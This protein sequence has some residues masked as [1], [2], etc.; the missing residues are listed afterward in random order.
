MTTYFYLHSD[1]PTPKPPTYEE[2]R[3]SKIVVKVTGF[4]NGKLAIYTVHQL[5]HEWIFFVKYHPKTRRSP[6]RT[7]KYFSSHRVG[8]A[9]K[10]DPLGLNKDL[11]LDQF[12][13]SR[14]KGEGWKITYPGGKRN[15]KKMLDRYSTPKTIPP[16]ERPL[17]A[18][19]SVRWTSQKVVNG[20]PRSAFG[21]AGEAQ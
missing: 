18:G 17:Q 8:E 9:R 7:W 10:Y 3:Q 2:V 21:R 4:E 16:D 14:Y 13:A 6:R 1:K 11:S 19:A 12:L 5:S 15:F 20:R